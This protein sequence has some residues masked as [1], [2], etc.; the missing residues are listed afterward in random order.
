MENKFSLDFSF[1]QEQ[2]KTFAD[3]SGD[4]NPIHLDESYAS[5]TTFKK[6]IIHGFLGA[7]IFSRIFGTLYPG[8]GTIY[9]KQDLKFL[10]PMFVDTRYLATVEIIE[11]FRE[12][13]RAKLRTYI[14]DEAGNIT[15]D[16]EALIKNTLFV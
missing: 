10:A 5:T 12:K 11:V 4:N 1:T 7:S 15:I 14:Q 6:R 16:G 13:K 8:G 9:L 3:V 2:V